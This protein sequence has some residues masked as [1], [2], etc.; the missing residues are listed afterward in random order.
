LNVK[1]KPIVNSYLDGVAFEKK[2]NVKV[3]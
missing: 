3:F 1:G 2:Y